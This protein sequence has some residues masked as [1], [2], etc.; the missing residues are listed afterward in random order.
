MGKRIKIIFLLFIV[1]LFLA[2]SATSAGLFLFAEEKV[3]ANSSGAEDVIRLTNTY[4]KSMGLSELT[5]NPRLTQ[6]A[7]NKAKDIIAKQYFSHT[8]PEGKKFSNWIKETGY[9]Y[10]YVGENLAID[11]GNPE[12]IFNAWIASPGHR[13]NIERPEFQEIG[14]A[15]ISGEYEGRQTIISVQEFGSRVL[16]ANETNI[17]NVTNSGATQNYFKTDNTNWPVIIKTADTYINFS[18]L[19]LIAMLLLWH[20]QEKKLQLLTVE[21]REAEIIAEATTQKAPKP[22]RS[23]NKQSRL[24]TVT[25]SSAIKTSLKSN[26]SKPQKEHRMTTTANRLHQR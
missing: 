17:N 15:Y 1:T 24:A 10:F 14:V 4:R 26:P 13:A 19:A 8:S 23:D 3:I 21:A 25:P 7:I 18:L 6:A 9:N 2:K 12:E 11:F 16:S 20:Q 22:K 5:T